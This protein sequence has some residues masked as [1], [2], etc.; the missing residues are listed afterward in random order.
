MLDAN[1]L[2][3]ISF[4]SRKRKKYKFSSSQGILRISAKFQGV[5]A[6][7]RKKNPDFFDGGGKLTNV[8]QFQGGN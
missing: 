8:V 5:F 7:N 3:L 4:E 6:Y 2:P 1:C